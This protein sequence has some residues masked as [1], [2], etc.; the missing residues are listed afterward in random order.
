MLSCLRRRKDP[1]IVLA[2]SGKE[3]KQS[4]MPRESSGMKIPGDDPNHKN[5]EYRHPGLGLWGGT[6]HLHVFVF[7][8]CK[9][10]FRHCVAPMQCFR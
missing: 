6:F 1:V 10:T 3:A 8:F 9:S 5:G 7:N 4:H 2:P